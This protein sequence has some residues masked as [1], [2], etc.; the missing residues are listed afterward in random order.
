MAGLLDK[1]NEMAAKADEEK[2]PKTAEPVTTAGKTEAAKAEG[3]KKVKATPKLK[4]PATKKTGDKKPVAKKTP[5]IANA[6][7]LKSIVDKSKVAGG[8]APCPKASKLHKHLHKVG[9]D[10]MTHKDR[11]EKEVAEQ[12]KKVKKMMF[13]VFWIVAIVLVLIVVGVKNC[14]SNGSKSTAAP[15]RVTYSASFNSF[16]SSMEAYVKQEDSDKQIFFD[17]FD[18][19]IKKHPQDKKKVLKLKNT[20]MRVYE[21]SE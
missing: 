13:K 19:Y 6:D 12:A 21:I 3:E 10:G 9:S 2:S 4:T 11:I 18:E 20:L 15:S 16:R 14:R 8:K 1:M 17:K 7:K 5:A